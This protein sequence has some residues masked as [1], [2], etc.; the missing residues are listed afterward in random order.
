VPTYLLSCFLS[1]PFLTETCFDSRSVQVVW[2]SVDARPPLEAPQVDAF[3]TSLAA[4]GRRLA[5]R[6][7]RASPLYLFDDPR[8]A[9]QLK[10]KGRMRGCAPSACAHS[11]R[12]EH[13]P[14]AAI[15]RRHCTIFM[16]PGSAHT[17]ALSMFRV[18][19][20]TYIYRTRPRLKVYGSLYI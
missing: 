17:S 7:A 20:Y 3:M 16:C 4:S 1:L 2:T 11:E 19:Q 14:S 15:W 10:Q 8:E 12:R 9:A 6:F 13:P 5:A 18:I